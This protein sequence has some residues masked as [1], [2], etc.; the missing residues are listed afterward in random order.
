[1]ARIDDL[2][3]NHA[4]WK[5]HEECF[6]NAVGKRG[7]CIEIQQEILDELFRLRADICKK[8]G[9]IAFRETFQLSRYPRI[10]NVIQGYFNQGKIDDN[11]KTLTELPAK[12]DR[13]FLE[14][15]QKIL[16]PDTCIW[17][18]KREHQYSELQEILQKHISNMNDV[19]VLLDAHAAG[20]TIENLL[21][22]TSDINDIISNKAVIIQHLGKIKDIVR[23]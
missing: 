11:G 21:F 20:Q 5:T 13:A 14:Q 4:G 23:P 2:E 6:G 18:P 15:K 16:N 1:M 8:G 12:Y 19:E 22:I 17:H 10:G 9:V 3:P 7:R